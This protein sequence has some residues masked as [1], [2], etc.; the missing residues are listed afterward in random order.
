MTTATIPLSSTIAFDQILESAVI[1]SWMHFMPDTSTSLAR[2]E[3][4]LGPDGRMEYLQVWSSIKRGHEYLV[5]DWTCTP[6]ATNHVKFSNDFY[7][8]ALAQ[9]LESIIQHQAEF[10]TDLA[11]H[12]D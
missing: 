2:V 12:R 10:L 1:L 11:A 8:K 7:S 4:R 3:Y 9:M 6:T 5:C